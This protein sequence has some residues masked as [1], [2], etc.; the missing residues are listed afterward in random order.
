M[1]VGG[2]W[3]RIL[4]CEDSVSVVPEH[5]R[6]SHGDSRVLVHIPTGNCYQVSVGDDVPEG[7]KTTI[8]NLHARLY[9]IPEGGIVPDSKAQ[10][11]FARAAIAVWMVD[12]GLWKPEIM[13]SPNRPGHN[14]RK[15]LVR[16][17]VQ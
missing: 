2:N 10:L 7:T 14:S 16:G 9:W 13:D 15:D 4:R 6:P 12:K 11:D 1:Y 17:F 8:F 5:W 3:G